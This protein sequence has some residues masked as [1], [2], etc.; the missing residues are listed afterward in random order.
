MHILFQSV[1]GKGEM[2][3]SGP[4]GTFLLCLSSHWKGTFSVPCCDG[5]HI[6]EASQR[7]HR[8]QTTLKSP[9]RRVT[10]PFPV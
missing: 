3:V 5:I 9:I 10:F 7:S 4:Q 2:E 1:S 6:P 8:H